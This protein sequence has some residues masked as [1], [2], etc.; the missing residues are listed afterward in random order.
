[1]VLYTYKDLIS[2]NMKAEYFSII[3]TSVLLDLQT[4]V[5]IE[6]MNLNDWH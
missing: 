5:C 2:E 3:I 1:M 6:F 4:V